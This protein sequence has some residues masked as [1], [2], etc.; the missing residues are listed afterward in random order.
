MARRGDDGV[1]SHERPDPS[2]HKSGSGGDMHVSMPQ[3]RTDA[4]P[5]A[6]RTIMIASEQRALADIIQHEIIPRLHG[7]PTSAPA[8]F[9]VNA[10]VID[11]MCE[12]A[13]ANEQALIEQQILAAVGRDGIVSDT[14]AEIVTRTA[15]KLGEDWEN[16][17]R[18]FFD[19]TI[20][21]G[22]LQRVLTRFTDTGSA[23]LRLDRSAL[24]GAV[25]GETHTFGLA[26]VCHFFQQARWPVDFRPYAS[27]HDLK[28][29][30]ANEWY[31][32]FGLSIADRN[33]A[34]KARVLVD[35]L[36][37]ISVNPAIKV[38]V[39]GPAVVED[40]SL[41][42]EVGADALALNGRDAIAKANRW[43]DALP[44]PAAQ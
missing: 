41:V 16:D 39:G 36:R 34:A 1:K 3:L 5:S 30:L 38:L 2:D 35:D 25:P 23:A 11:A 43:A 44:R 37:R 26:V 17:T 13:V 12:A 20:G 15:R 33:D 31:T 10:N 28:V 22:T 4:E 7:I 6:N 19:V 32:L 21:L 27:L 40:E 9:G 24:L 14:L 8:A 18:D 42:Q 29:A